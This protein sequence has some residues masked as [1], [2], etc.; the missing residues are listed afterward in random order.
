MNGTARLRRALLF[1]PGS[2]PKK[3]EKAAALGVDGIIIDLEDGVA[4]GRK[5]EAR[6]LVQAALAGIDF[7]RSEVLVRI[8]DLHSGQEGDDL[9]SLAQGQRL[10]HGVVVPKVES[11]EELRYLFQ[12]LEP[13]ESGH[14]QPPGSLRVLAL[15]ETARGVVRLA[16]I[17]ASG[18]RLDALLFGAE[19]L[20]GSLGARR[21]KE[22]REVFYARSAVMVHAAAHGLQAIDTPFVDFNDEAGLR[23]EATLAADL[24]YDGKMAIH[25]RQIETILAV[26]CPQPDEIAHAERLIREHAQHQREG[27]GVFALDGKMVDMPMVRAAERV[28]AGRA[29]RSAEANVGRPRRFF[30]ARLGG[31][32]RNMERRAK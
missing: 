4:L 22:G 5:D 28:L 15:I 20:C 9:E 32:A 26:F 17:A 24:G 11:A 27:R 25:P 19:D 29:G 13:I 23:S 14:G 31:D 18:G 1:C 7:G 6:T 16:D 3:I 10:P 8:N 21:S 30:S 12:L 2:E